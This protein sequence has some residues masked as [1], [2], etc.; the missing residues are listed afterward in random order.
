[1]REGKRS[2]VPGGGEGLGVC[3]ARPPSSGTP[4][5]GLK[6]PVTVARPRKSL[7]PKLR[8]HGP[9]DGAWLW[10]R[11]TG[12]PPP[13][14]GLCAGGAVTPGARRRWVR[15]PRGHPAPATPPCPLLH[16]FLFPAAS[17]SDTVINNL[18]GWPL[19]LGRGEPEESGGD[20]GAAAPAWGGSQGFGLLEGILFS[21]GFFSAPESEAVEEETVCWLAE[22]SVG[23]C[24]VLTARRASLRGGVGAEPGATGLERLSEEASQDTQRAGCH[25]RRICGLLPKPSLAPCAGQT[26]RKLCLAFHLLP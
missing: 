15:S 22:Q 23:Q 20:P 24:R 19:G 11:V 8:A 7:R 14:G 2:R 17:S 5:A 4:N 9:G 26:H 16:N 21:R 18:E 1:M 12:K 25:V 6:A 3:P 10:E 13:P